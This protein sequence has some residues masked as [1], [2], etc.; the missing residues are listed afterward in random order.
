MGESGLLFEVWTFNYIHDSASWEWSGAT[1]SNFRSTC[2]STLE[3]PGSRFFTHTA[4]KSSQEGWLFGG[5]GVDCEGK[6][7]Y[8]SDLWRY[9][10]D[11]QNWTFVGGN[12]NAN[13][14]GIYQCC[15]SLPGGR[16]MGILWTHNDTLY[17]F[18]GYG[19]D[20]DGSLGY[21]YFILFFK[22]RTT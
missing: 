19:F 20:E 8:L 17:L 11:E 12:F 13:A 18:G 15:P 2:N 9:Q 22:R 3:N 5:Y 10:Y 7:G 6:K 4:R 16:Q 1:T 14:S 21:F